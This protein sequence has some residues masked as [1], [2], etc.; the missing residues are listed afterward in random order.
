MNP[1]QDVTVVMPAYNEATGI[2]EVVR[3][4]AQLPHVAEVVVVDNNSTDGTA[5]HAIAAGARVVTETNQ[6]Y[7][8]ACRR[9]L[10]ES[11]TEWALIVESDCTFWPTDLTKFLAYRDEF[12]VIFGTRTSKSC[13]WG[14]ANMGYF[15]RYGNAAV[16]KYLEYLHNGPCLTDVGC[17]Y[18]F[19]RRSVIQDVS[20]RWTIGDSSFSPELMI[21]CIRRGWRCIEIPVNYGRRVGDSKITGTF[22]KAFRLGLRMI[23]LITKYRLTQIPLYASPRNE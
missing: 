10:E 14:G 7:G 15:L 4:F 19:I 12:D 6:G 2:A 21:L 3:S 23:W 9:A 16:A 1:N 17:T 22:N 8:Y 20:Q 11:K 13:I 5:Q 18:K